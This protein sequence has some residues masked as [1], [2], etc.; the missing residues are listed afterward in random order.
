MLLFSVFSVYTC[1]QF[2]SDSI[3]FK[4]LSSS[5]YSLKHE[6]YFEMD[7]YR[8]SGYCECSLQ[9]IIIKTVKT[10]SLFKEMLDKS[11]PA[12]LGSYG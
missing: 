5:Q 10:I 3:I 11:E 2:I 7:S 12:C 1:K 6:Q 8:V 4:N 9:L